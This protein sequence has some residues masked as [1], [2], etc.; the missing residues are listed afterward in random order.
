LAAI[1]FWTLG[2]LANMTKGDVLAIAPCVLVFGGIL[3]AMRWRVNVLSLGE[4]EARTLGINVRLMR[5]LAI[6]SSTVITA[7]SVCVS[8]S[9]GWVGLIIPHV[10][11]L[12]VGNDN[13]RVLPA[14]ALLG[15]AFLVTV[16]T[17]ARCVSFS[18][19]PL[20]IITGLLGAPLFVVIIVKRRMT[21]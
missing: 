6:L 19:L 1:I 2:S 13:E 11:R 18:E 21:L 15:G 10:S 17:L 14:S 7:S 9:I 3:I 16:D 8:G 4:K 12:L 20:G 5:G